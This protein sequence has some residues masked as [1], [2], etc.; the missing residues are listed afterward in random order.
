MK[1][2]IITLFALVMTASGVVEA[3][4]NTTLSPTMAVP[5][6]T[7]SP[8]PPPITPFPTE[9]SIPTLPPVVVPVSYNIEREKILME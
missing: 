8:I 1:F 4:K 3:G 9:G 6:E 7:Y 5:R 2:T